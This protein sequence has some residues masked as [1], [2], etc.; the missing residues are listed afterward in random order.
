MHGVEF[1][2]KRKT[3]WQAM[4]RAKREK[5]CEG[6][7]GSAKR[8]KIYCAVKKRK[9]RKRKK[10]DGLF[11]PF[12]SEKMGLYIPLGLESLFG[13]CDDVL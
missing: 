4:E 11:K 7:K 3:G 10:A 12:E 5:R 1:L 8:E 6:E 2:R 9:G 13:R